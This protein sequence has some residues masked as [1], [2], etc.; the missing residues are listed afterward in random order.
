VRTWDDNKSAINQLW[1]QCQW[2]DE[3]RRLW[4][5]DL[6][7]LDQVVLYDAIRNVKR[8]HDTLYPQ[9]KWMLDSYRD[10]FSSK[11]RAMNQRTPGE[12]H[13]AVHVDSE[14]SKRLAAEFV[15]TIESATADDFDMIEGLV[16]DKVEHLKIDMLP[17]Y[18]VLMYARKR[19]LGQDAM[20]GRVGTDGEV[21]HVSA[22]GE[23]K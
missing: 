16:L 20:F 1:P 13:K 5:D 6:A 14:Q 11:R 8:T 15:A 22:I 12:S 21:Q 3:E 2:T 19:L 4:S 17:A 23:R 10:L 18:R 7:R 9:L